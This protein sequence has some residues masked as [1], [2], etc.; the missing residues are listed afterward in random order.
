MYVPS[1]N[2]K[3]KIESL[4]Q[5]FWIDESELGEIALLIKL[6][7][8]LVNS[9]VKGVPLEIVIR[10]PHIDKR[11]CTLY[12]HDIIDEPF[13][14]TG[15]FFGEADKTV[16]DFD[17]VTLAIATTNKIIVSLYNLDSKPIHT[18]ELSIKCEEN[19]HNWLF[20][21]YNY[22]EYSE[23]GEKMINGCYLPENHKKGFSIQI[24]NYDSSETS[25][26]HAIQLNMDKKGDIYTTHFNL[27][28][29]GDNGK[30][31][32]FQENSIE[33][34]LRRHFVIN[35]EFYCSPQNT[36]ETEFTDFILLSKSIVI[37]IESKYI[38]SKKQ[39]KINQALKK[40]VLQL[41][42]IKSQIN[43][44][45]IDLLDKSLEKQLMNNRYIVKVCLINDRVILS[46]DNTKNLI[47]N[48]AKEDLPIFIP[49]SIFN[50]ILGAFALKDLNNL[51]ERFT[52]S[53]FFESWSYLNSDKPIAYIR[54]FKINGE[55]IDVN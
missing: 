54:D 4:V 38:I 49:V 35:E 1:T 36:D 15:K 13:Y 26:F 23:Q 11:S 29:Y 55:D 10:N 44:N 19:I 43:D 14:V 28:N 31:G 51:C 40:A 39:T 41:K 53:L 8:S 6:E 27:S 34:I 9:I 18:K 37:L 7:A 16:P 2:A 45:L 21:I 24:I 52:Q 48:F 3:S 46:E 32:Y 33:S 22:H 42:K 17:K 5:G 30:H 47:D 50:Q 20:K 25:D 12:I